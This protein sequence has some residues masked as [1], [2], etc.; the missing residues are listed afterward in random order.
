MLEPTEHEVDGDLQRSMQLFER[1]RVGPVAPIVPLRMNRL[2]VVLD[3]SSQD[4]TGTA[5][6]KGLQQRF[7]VETDVLDAREESHG[8]A[9]AASAAGS[10]SA[11]SAGRR[12][13]A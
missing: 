6:A 1:S 11:R 4:A 10:L 7:E 13:T 12:R 8:D 2:L 5:I 9:L 3:G